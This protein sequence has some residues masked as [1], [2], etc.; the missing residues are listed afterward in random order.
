MHDRDSVEPFQPTLDSLAGFEVPD[1]FRDAKLGIWS[2]WGPQSVPRFGDWYARHLYREGSDQYLYHRRT[3]GHPS[4]FGY[5]DLVAL[6]KAERF[7]PEALMD[8]YVAAGAKYFVS[9]AV[10][11]DNFLNYDSALHSWNSARIG[12]ERDI[13]A[14][15]RAAAVARGLRFGLSEHL[16]AS[17][18]WLATSKGADERGPYKGVPYDGADPAHVE[19]YLPNEDH[20]TRDVLPK[21]W[22]TTNPWWHRRWLELTNEM[23]DKFQPDLLYSDGP[24][25]FDS[26][27]HAAGAQV[28][29]NLYNTS[30]RTHGG[31]NAAVYTQKTRDADLVR[32]G[33]LDVERSQEPEI[34][35][36]PW[37]TDT[38]VGGWFYDVRARYKSPEHVLEILVDV[39][40]KNGNLLLNIPQLPDGTIDD[41]CSY[42]LDAMARWTAI[43]GEGIFGTRP[44][45]VYGEGPGRVVIDHFREDRVEWTSQ[46]F[47][48][49]QRGNVV[50]AFLMRWPAEGSALI[51][52]LT[53]SDTVRSVRLLGRGQVDWRHTDEGLSVRLPQTSPAEELNCLA[54]ELT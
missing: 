32:I 28:V 11:H 49:T 14:A 22:Y 13:V 39:V 52:S 54:I 53:R 16:G 15:W 41:E 30:A 8:R 24:L 19:L 3:Y 23:I 46:D 35:P 2:H 33:V 7:D 20:H 37:Q 10:H 36:D 51:R 4:R 48:F 9:Q 29:A 44:F 5:K 25:P 21:P 17:F 42:L 27:D 18:S 26:D 43:C 31:R 50:Y 6:W 47:R 12:P 1:W 45:R 34:R 40:A 38:C